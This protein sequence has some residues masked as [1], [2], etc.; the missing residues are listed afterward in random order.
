MLIC[1]C[2]FHETYFFTIEKVHEP[3]NKADS[4]KTSLPDDLEY[5]TRPPA[6]DRFVGLYYRLK[7]LRDTASGNRAAEVEVPS[8][9]DAGHVFEK[10]MF[11]LEV[12]KW[13]RVDRIPEVIGNYTDY[14]KSRLL[15]A[16][17]RAMG[18]DH[19]GISSR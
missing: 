15:P 9:T 13:T 10:A 1:F 5:I 19:P 4:V 2:F 16:H 14:W 12:R 6:E 18:W 3:E 7:Y 17:F 8:V 11:D